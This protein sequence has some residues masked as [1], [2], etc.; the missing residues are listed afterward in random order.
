MWRFWIY[1]T[2][3]PEGRDGDEHGEIAW[4]DLGVDA[5]TGVDLHDADDDTTVV[6]R[7]HHH[8][9]Q[10]G[11]TPPPR[12]ETRTHS[13]TERQA[14]A[15]D[16]YDQLNAMGDE[17]EPLR[18]G[19]A[20]KLASIGDESLA[21]EHLAQALYSHRESVRRAATYG[22][23]AVGEGVYGYLFESDGFACEMGEEGG[24]VR[25]GRQ[26]LPERSGLRTP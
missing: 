14:E 16:L 7:Y 13:S 8:W 5:L 23:I 10:T 19:A 1:R 9:M 20:Y 15:R 12:P 24:R 2:T 11:S 22:L 4:R 6:W 26:R 21:V 18:I 17:A 25:A 3:E